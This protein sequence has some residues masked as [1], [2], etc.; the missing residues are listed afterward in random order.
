MRHLKVSSINHNFFVQKGD[1]WTGVNPENY[2]IK[3][4]VDFRVEIEE[5]RPDGSFVPFKADDIQLE[6]IRLDPYHR[7]F[8]K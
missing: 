2:R 6:F 3:D 4:E 8:L 5:K 7:I 1:K